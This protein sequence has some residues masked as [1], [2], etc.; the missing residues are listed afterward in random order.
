VER[1][2]LTVDENSSRFGMELHSNCIDVLTFFLSCQV[3][4]FAVHEEY[5]RLGPMYE[6]VSRSFRGQVKKLNW[7]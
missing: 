5:E 6:E 7:A 3:L 2:L 1:I 4:L